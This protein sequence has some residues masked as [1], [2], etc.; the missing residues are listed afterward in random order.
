MIPVNTDEQVYEIQ[1][2]INPKYGAKIYPLN[3]HKGGAGWYL[4]AVE[5]K[6]ALSPKEMRE[7][8]GAAVVDEL[9]AE[10][11]KLHILE[12]HGE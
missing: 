4:Y 11:N 2:E 6:K 10:C 9:V 3:I 12:E 7:L 8:V 5:D 1:S